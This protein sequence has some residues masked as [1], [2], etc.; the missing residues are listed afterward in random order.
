MVL[1]DIENN[2]YYLCIAP[3]CNT[4][5][6]QLTGNIIKRMAPHRPMRFIR[7]ANK[8]DIILKKLKNANQSNTIFISDEGTR[9]A[10]DIFEEGTNPTIEQGVVVD[11]D[12]VPIE[13]EGN[14][15]VQFLETNQKT[16]KLEIV[17]RK[18]KPIAKLRAGFAS[19]YQNAQLQYEA[20]IGV[21]LV[22]GIMA[23]S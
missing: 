1:R 21:D 20:R 4:I 23:D 9:L 3:G 2:E 5:P 16:H 6:N 8:T 19:R 22:S 10:L 12:T 14:K 17:E 11:H 18:L 13:S 7:L 15:A